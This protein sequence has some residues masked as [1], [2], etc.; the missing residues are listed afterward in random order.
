MHRKPSDSAVIKT[1]SKRYNTHKPHKKGRGQPPLPFLAHYLKRPYCW[2][3]WCVPPL[4][5]GAGSAA[6]SVVGFENRSRRKLGLKLGNAFAHTLLECR[7]CVG[8]HGSQRFLQVTQLLLFFRQGTPDW[9]V[10]R[11]LAAK[12]AHEQTLHQIKTVRRGRGTVYVLKI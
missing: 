8:L 3:P 6:G 12:S 2:P 7:R 4:L 1:S 5:P 9:L 11:H 10:I